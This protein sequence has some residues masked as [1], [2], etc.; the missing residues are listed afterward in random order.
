MPRCYRYLLIA[1]LLPAGIP[2]QAADLYRWQDDQ[3]NVYYTDRVPPEYVKHGYR[4]ISEQ[5]MTIR[6]IK[7]LEELEAE[8]ATGQ[9]EVPAEQLKQDRRLL[10]TY[11]NEDEILASRARRLEDI[12]SLIELSEETIVLLEGRFRQLAKEA[13]DYEKQGRTIPESLLTQIAA[14]RKKISKYQSRLE[15][16]N[17]TLKQTKSAFD[18]DLQ[19][20]RELKRMMEADE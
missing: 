1:C 12:E 9:P 5:G 18:S 17:N 20:Y 8:S 13:G 4:V 10:M 16:H 2:S 7:S 14:T 6:T 11:S 3:G 15:R 19:R